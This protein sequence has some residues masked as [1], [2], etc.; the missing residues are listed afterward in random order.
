MSTSHHRSKVRRNYQGSDTNSFTS[1]Y[2]PARSWVDDVVPS[3]KD[4]FHLFASGSI[5][6]HTALTARN[7]YTDEGLQP[8][9]T[10]LNHSQNTSATS[11]K[12]PLTQQHIKALAP[13]H[14]LSQHVIPHFVVPQS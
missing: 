12:K 5:L 8:L 14:F 11:Q 3:E 13:S 10:C 1:I 7:T 2:D 9:P 6:V 4:S